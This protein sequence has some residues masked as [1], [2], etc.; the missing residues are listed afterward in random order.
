[1]TLGARNPGLVF[2][3]GGFLIAHKASALAFPN[4]PF[5]FALRMGKAYVAAIKPDG[6]AGAFLRHGGGCC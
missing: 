5:I 4:D 2:A 1:M 6:D 3:E